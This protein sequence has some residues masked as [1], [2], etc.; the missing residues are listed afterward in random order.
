MKA[1]EPFWAP[2]KGTLPVL[3]Y[4]KLLCP[5]HPIFILFKLSQPWT[6]NHCGENQKHTV[7]FDADTYGMAHEKALILHAEYRM[8]MR[9]SLSVG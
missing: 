2:G 8:L 1:S 9:S 6:R 4:I 3:F 5:R 7:L